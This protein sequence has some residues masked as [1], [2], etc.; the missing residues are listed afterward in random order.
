[1]VDR[2]V[3]AY[4]ATAHTGQGMEGHSPNEV[5]ATRKSRRVLVDGVLDLLC[6][7]WSGELTVGKNG[8][9][10]KGLW[11]GQYSTALLMHQ[12]RKVRVSYDPGDLTSVQVYDA[13]SWQFITTA[14]QARLVGYGAGA[15]EEALREAMTA[16]ARARKIVKGF[17]KASRT[18]NMDLTSLTIETM[19]S[20]TNPDPAPTAAPAMRPAASVISNH[21]AIPVRKAAGAEQ[22]T[23]VTDLG[24]DWRDLK[25]GGNEPT[26]DYGFDFRKMKQREEPV[27]L[28]LFDNG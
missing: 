10:F 3:A 1:M 23:H 6:R 18:A 26:A 5:M 11:F 28:R 12:G 19:E 20:R 25:Q 15:D 27:D 8:V 13:A 14:E 16:K 22:V 7:V 2:Y 9:Q 17:R 24:L 4:N 21:T